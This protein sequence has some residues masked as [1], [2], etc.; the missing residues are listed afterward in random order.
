MERATDEDFARPFRT[1]LIVQG[2][3]RI[4]LMLGRSE[5]CGIVTG[6]Q[7]GDWLRFQMDQSAPI[8]TIQ[9]DVY[10]VTNGQNEYNS[11]LVLVLDTIE[12]IHR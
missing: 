12:G 5:M 9:Q 6:H 7:G 2:K 8:F 4:V 3:Q 1:L 10:V 11:V